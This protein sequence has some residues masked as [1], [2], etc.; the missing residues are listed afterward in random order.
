[1]LITSQPTHLQYH[2]ALHGL[3]IDVEGCSI[4]W[5]LLLYYQT[6]KN[7]VKI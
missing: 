5:L 7:M 2:A 3:K 1:M 6:V 4:V